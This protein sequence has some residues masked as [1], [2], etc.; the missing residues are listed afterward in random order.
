MYDKLRNISWLQSFR[1]VN[2][3]AISGEA[4]MVANTERASLNTG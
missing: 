2:L 1:N 3:L 4:A